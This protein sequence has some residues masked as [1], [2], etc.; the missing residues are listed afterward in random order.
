MDVDIFPSSNP[1]AWLRLTAD[2]I[3]KVLLESFTD[4]AEPH[5]WIEQSASSARQ[6]R[7][8][9]FPIKFVETVTASLPAQFYRVAPEVRNI[10]R[11]LGLRRGVVP[12]S[13]KLARER[14][15]AFTNLTRVSIQSPDPVLQSAAN[16]LKEY[17]K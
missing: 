15:K 14:E 5:S 13:T 11:D 7:P 4:G 16:S 12:S 2:G 17:L 8:V 3:E 9:R 6:G 10:K 1:Y